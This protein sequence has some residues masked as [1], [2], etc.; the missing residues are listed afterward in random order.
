MSQNMI[1]YSK[2]LI[3]YQK[4]MNSLIEVENELK[5]KADPESKRKL[6]KVRLQKKLNKKHWKEFLQSCQ[7]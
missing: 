7:S 2:N 4:A 3:G 1:D 5:Y 6:T